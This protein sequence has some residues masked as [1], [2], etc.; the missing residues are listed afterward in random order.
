LPIETT[1][2]DV[3]DLPQS[4]AETILV[5]A[6]L[7]VGTITM[8]FDEI[9]IAGNVVSS[10]PP[11]GLVV[12]S[13]TSV[14]LMISKGVESVIEEPDLSITSNIPANLIHVNDT[15]ELRAGEGGTDYVWLK[16]GLLIDADERISGV[17][18]RVLIIEEISLNDTGI[19]TCQF[20][21][22]GSL[23]ESEQFEIIEILGVQ[24]LPA[25]SL[26]GL[27]LLTALSTGLGVWYRNKQ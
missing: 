5:E 27:L 16:D 11:A 8:I 9:I 15:L 17:D 18:T 10:T 12:M 24:F 25:S 4:E 26:L 23:V 19:Y 7:L 22:F 6:G 21:F 3:I 13:G 1:V 14:D 2:P 20:S